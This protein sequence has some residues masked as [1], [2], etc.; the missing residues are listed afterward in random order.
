MEPTQRQLKALHISDRVVDGI[1]NFLESFFSTYPEFTWDSDTTKSRINIH[2]FD[3]FNLDSVDKRPRIAV[4]LLESRWQNVMVD[5]R[6]AVNLQKGTVVTSDMV[7][8][9]ITLHCVSKQSLEAKNLADIVFEAIRIFR[10]EIRRENAFS[11][12]DSVNIGREQRV[13]TSSQSE[14]RVVPVSVTVKLKRTHTK[15]MD[16]EKF[17]ASGP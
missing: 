9:S 2:D 8:S 6:Q 16:R 14:V 11:D 5:S 7:Q 4:E 17:E 1:I 12:I 3:A 10:L 13:R 15:I